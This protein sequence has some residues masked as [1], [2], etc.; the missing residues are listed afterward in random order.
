MVP[1]NR[2]R[3]IAQRR[4]K[5]NNLS[6]DFNDYDEPEGIIVISDNEDDSPKPAVND[7]SDFHD[8]ADPDDTDEDNVKC[9]V[10]PKED[11][12]CYHDYDDPEGN[13]S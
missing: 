13:D 4:Q 5:L 12:S 9:H 8:Y 7:S 1:N 10:T 3:R 11:L 2:P 6:S